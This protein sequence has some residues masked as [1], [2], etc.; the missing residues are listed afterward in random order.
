VIVWVGDA[1]GRLAAAQG[2]AGPRVIEV[3]AK[4]YEFAPSRLEVGVGE[5]V[6]I[7]VRSGDGLQG[8]GIRQFN[9]S[10]EVAKGESVT[11]DFTPK[12]AGEFPV[13]STEYCGDGH[14]VMTGTLVVMARE[15]GKP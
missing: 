3:V 9:V 12:A 1:G 15:S 10:R 4:R 8:F 5:R 7:V 6:H 13:L 14:D 2:S 11:I